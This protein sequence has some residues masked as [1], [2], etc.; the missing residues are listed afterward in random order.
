MRQLRKEN[1]NK[2]LK[3]VKFLDTNAIGLEIGCGYGWF[4]E[5][6]ME[7]NLNCEG[8]EPETRFNDFYQLHGFKVR[9]GFYPDVINKSEQYDFVAFNDVL[10]H[11]PEI[12]KT[13]NC[14]YDILKD[15]GLLII[16]IPIQE[17]LFYFFSK[18]AYRFGYSELLNRMWQFNFHSPHLYYFRKRNIKDL[19]KRYGF[20][21]NNSFKLKTIRFSELTSRIKQDKSQNLIQF[22]ISYIG[23]IILFPFTRIFPDTFCFIFQ[24]KQLVND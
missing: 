6:C 7:Q 22:L 18:V 10:E 16:N 4:L 19:G 1:F 9:N 14:N 12:E 8:I 21:I 3:A 5:S 20:L 24:K 15:N 23:S 17:G 2:I 11:I 13:M